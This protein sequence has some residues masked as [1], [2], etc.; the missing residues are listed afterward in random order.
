MRII[1]NLSDMIEEEL[2]GAAEYARLAISLKEEDPSTAKVLAQISEDESGHVKRLHDA[3]SVIINRYRSEHG[4]PPDTM[5]AVY[6]Y[7]HK[8]QIAT[9]E[10]VKNL[11]NTF[12]EN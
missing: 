8:K 6:D 2:E 1:E 5:K 10:R 12:R 3:V 11:Q 4:D 9:A 7:L